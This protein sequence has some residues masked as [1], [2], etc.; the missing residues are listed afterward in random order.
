MNRYQ[1]FSFLILSSFSSESLLLAQN[2][3]LKERV[4]S[5]DTSVTQYSDS[6]DSY[7]WY[8][9]NH[10][11]IVFR[12][13]TQFFDPLGGYGE[14]EHDTSQWVLF[15]STKFALQFSYPPQFQVRILDLNSHK[16]PDRPEPDSAIQLGYQL[17]L[18]PSPDSTSARFIPVVTV[19]LSSDS[20]AQIAQDEGFEHARLK[21]DDSGSVVGTSRQGSKKWIM[22]VDQPDQDASYLDGFYWKGLRCEILLNQY[23]SG[24]SSSS[25]HVRSFLTRTRT[26]GLAI[27]ASYDDEP[28]DD[29]EGEQRTIIEENDFYKIVGSIRF[30]N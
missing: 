30:L 9:H 23:T 7:I 18:H 22:P 2:T 27:V 8:A 15:T 4:W 10:L 12:Y 11:G 26:D 1:L 6:S 3:R 29:A 28:P 17:V 13:S 20:F 19:Y 24:P 21:L 25:P 16:P 5:P 14:A